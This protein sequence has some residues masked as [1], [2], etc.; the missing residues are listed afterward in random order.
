MNH[1]SLVLDANIAVKILHDEHDSSDAQNLLRACAI[2][3]LS[4][5]VPEHFL[6]ELINVCQR[7][8][9]ETAQVLKFFEAMEGSIL[10]VVSPDYAAWI[11]AEKI[12]LEGH[13]KMGFPS[14]Y[15][16]IY[17][18]IAIRAKAVFV[19]ADK[20]HFVKTERFSHICLLKDWKMF[21]V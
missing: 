2:Q 14:M 15:D 8:S 21:L 13:P 4:V 18:A 7:L 12:A 6:Y 17:H 16:S 9:I 3:N 20:R 1:Q 19:T 11:L 10:N 5:L